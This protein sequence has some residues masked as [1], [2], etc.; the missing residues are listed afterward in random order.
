MKRRSFLT[1]LATL[2]AWVSVRPKLHAD[3]VNASLRTAIE[4]LRVRIHLWFGE[5]LVGH[6]TCAPG[7]EREFVATNRSTFDHR[8]GYQFE[9][10][11]DAVPNL[12]TVFRRSLTSVDALDAARPE[13][14]VHY[15]YV[16][17]P[18]WWAPAPGREWAFIGYLPD[19][20][21]IF[22]RKHVTWE[23]LAGYQFTHVKFLADGGLT[24]AE[25]NLVMSRIRR[26]P[27]E[28]LA[29]IRFEGTPIRFG[30]QR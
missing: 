7:E 29:R 15:S 17:G 2:A 20:A 24:Q 9:T 13:M 10:D 5:T 28:P 22:Q 26:R 11:L 6:F 1:L 19:D 12:E 25:K 14:H 21:L 4:P 23:H 16:S 3:A 30:A 18:K 8:R 27:G